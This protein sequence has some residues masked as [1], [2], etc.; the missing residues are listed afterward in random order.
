MERIYIDFLQWD[1][2]WWIKHYNIKAINALS[3]YVGTE[4]NNTMIMP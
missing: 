1:S 4:A 2:T 3:E